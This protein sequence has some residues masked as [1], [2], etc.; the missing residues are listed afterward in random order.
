[1]DAISVCAV[2]L[3]LLV[4]GPVGNNPIF[5]SALRDLPHERR[6]GIIGRECLIAVAEQLQRRLGERV[7]PAF[8]RLMG[9]ILAAIA[10]EL[11]LRGIKTFIAEL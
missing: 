5:S 3:R 9:L 7:V 2:V 8:E 1:M 10:V 4:C 11:M 6:G